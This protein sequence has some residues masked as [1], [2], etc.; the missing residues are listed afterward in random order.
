[1]NLRIISAIVQKDMV[2]AIKNKTILFSILLPIGF[3]LL[4]GF[5][6]KSEDVLKVAVFDEGG[7]ALIEGL[8]QMEGV[9]IVRC[10]T[11]AQ[12]RETVEKGAN[13]GLVLPPQFDQA[14]AQGDKPSLQIYVNSK[15]G[16][17]GPTFFRQ[18]IQEQ[19]MELA[20]QEMPAD[21]RLEILNAPPE[22]E[23]EHFDIKQ[24][25]LVMWLVLAL[26]GTGA[27][28][29]PTLLAEEKEKHTLAA[30]LVS[31]ASYV[32][33][34]AA[35]AIVG[36]V[37]ALL[38]ALILL[39][40]NGGLVGNLALLFTTILLSSLLLVEIGLLVGGLF[41]NVTQVNTWS[42]FVLLPLMLPGMLLAFPGVLEV[43]VR[44]IPTYYTIDAVKL[45]L[46]DQATLSNVWLDL[47]VLGGCAV[48][49]FVAVVWS[50]N[51]AFAQN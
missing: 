5:V 11:G 2:D 23:E 28:V 30:I 12:V 34:V 7:S 48:A 44:L 33:V 25:M 46:T 41:E 43:V 15:K 32:D 35:K 14:V 49:L 45:A 20:G 21:V 9:E 42:T 27:F 47:A 22:G 37:Y 4:F 26:A 17:G 31:P 38:I 8:A 24:Y 6:F 1:M 3:S 50:L 40:L 13:G 51:V 29:V 19:L 36:L 18:F 39:A 10:D 16:G